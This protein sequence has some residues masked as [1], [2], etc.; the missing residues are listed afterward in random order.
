MIH[1]KMWKTLFLLVFVAAISQYLIA[2]SA[3]E[4]AKLFEQNACGACHTKDMKTDLVGPALAGVRDRWDNIDELYDWVRNSD[5]MIKKGHKYG[6]ALFEKYNKVP[7]NVYPNLT[8]KD[9]E[10][11]L[12][13]IESVAGGGAVAGGNTGKDG[14]TQSMIDKGKE[15]FDKNACAAC[16]SK[17]MKTDLTGPALS[18]VV[19]RWP[20]KKELYRWIRNSS[21]MIA[22]GHK[23]SVELFEKYKKVPMLPYPNLTD[24]EIDAVLAYIQYPDGLPADT[25]AVAVDA[26]VVKDEVASKSFWGSTMFYILLVLVFGALVLFLAMKLAH[27]KNLLEEKYYGEKGNHSIFS[28]FTSRNIMK[29]ATFG[30][31]V[32]GL[33]FTAVKAMNLGRQQN[34]EPEQPILFSHVTHAGVNKID[35]QFCHDGA[36]KSK[37][38]VIPATNTCLKCHKAI[39]VGSEYGTQELTKIY[40]SI[41]YDPQTNQFIEN[42]NELSQEDVKKIFTSWIAKQN[43]DFDDKAVNEQWDLIVK[44]LTNELKPKVQGPIMWKKIHNLPDHVYFNH[45]QHVAVG[46][47][48]C[49]ECHGPVEEMK[50]VRQYSTLSMGWCINCHRKTEVQFADNPYYK[51]FA[52]FHEEIKKGTRDQ[53]TVEEIGGLDCNKC[54]Y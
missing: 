14:I 2:Q 1:K 29:Y 10:S 48:D 4:G 40:A 23:Y 36:A 19:D 46:K 53:V 17:D 20:D 49:T 47:L 12:L 31:V 37:H 13:Y 45:A 26:P 33:F 35:C 7:M 11:I 28:V 9:I 6:N 3:E 38:A 44:S 41:G 51:N 15:V 42:Y 18:G 54:H 16:H 22:E 32:F 25:T 50:V 8:N 52:K 5:Q 39:K 43:Q 30:L 21:E 34:Y 24:E 27:L